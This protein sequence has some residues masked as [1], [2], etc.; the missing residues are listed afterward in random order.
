[1]MKNKMKI[2]TDFL[3]ELGSFLLVPKNVAGFA[4]LIL[5]VFVFLSFFAM[6][7]IDIAF[8]YFFVRF[9]LTLFGFLALLA[10]IKKIKG[11]EL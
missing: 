11:E 6:V 10:I 4:I 7:W 8:L 3:S 9:I 2:I 5:I 1:M